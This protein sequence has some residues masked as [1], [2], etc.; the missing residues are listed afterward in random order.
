MNAP[1]EDLINAFPV[2]DYTYQ[3]PTRQGTT[4]HF[5]GMAR[6]SGTSFSTPLV[7]APVAAR[8]SLTGENGREPADSLLQFARQQAVPGLGATLRPG[9]AWA[10]VS[11]TMRLP[12]S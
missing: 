11:T 10:S 8:M 4:E 7:A 9:D 3:E 6:W 5:D 1:G 2:G 12:G